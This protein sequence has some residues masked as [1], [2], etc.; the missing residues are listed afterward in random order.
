MRDV[1]PT[2]KYSA[3]FAGFTMKCPTCQHEN[4]VA[5]KFCEQCAAPLAGHC[6]NCG[7]QFSATANFCPQCGY[8]VRLIGEAHRLASPHDYTPPYA[9]G[10]NGTD[11][12][13]RLH[14]C[15]RLL[16]R[17]RWRDHLMAACWVL[18][19]DGGQPDRQFCETMQPAYEDLV[20]SPPVRF[21]I[22]SAIA[23][24]VPGYESS[25]ANPWP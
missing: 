22:A 9:R 19:I 16:S 13:A 10:A 12:Q 14:P 8:P 23:E 11:R 21:A 15:R 5:A 17:S 18:S 6:D 4:S 7:A 20:F 1:T 25:V 3:F 2:G 24:T